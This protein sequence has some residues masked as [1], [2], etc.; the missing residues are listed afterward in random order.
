[1]VEPKCA[2]GV[3]FCSTH[4]EEGEQHSVTIRLRVWFYYTYLFFL[5]LNF[6]LT[7]PWVTTNTPHAHALSNLYT[8]HITILIPSNPLFSQLPSR[9][10]TV[11]P[12]S[13]STLKWCPRED[14]CLVLW[15]VINNVR[16]TRFILIVCLYNWLI[17]EGFKVTYMQ[18]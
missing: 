8:I 1:M 12:S 6:L 9:Y 16:L 18:D 2:G 17:R 11:Q 13:C 3:Y 7:S 14:E 10:L 15:F 5:T 4:Y